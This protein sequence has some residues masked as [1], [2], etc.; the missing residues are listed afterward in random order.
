MIWSGAP[1]ATLCLMR[2]SGGNSALL[3]CAPLNPTYGTIELM[4]ESGGKICY[5]SKVYTKMVK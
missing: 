2:Q 5:R 3:G 4:E 1:D